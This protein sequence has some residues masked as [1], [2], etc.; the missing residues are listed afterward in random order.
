MGAADSLLSLPTPPGSRGAPH[1]TTAWR[2]VPAG[3][4][5]KPWDVTSPTLVSVSASLSVQHPPQH[6][7]EGPDPLHGAPQTDPRVRSVWCGRGGAAPGGS[8]AGRRSR[9]QPVV[10]TELVGES[11]LKTGWSQNSS[12]L[13]RSTT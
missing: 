7:P 9:R 6:G 3:A 11:L 2:K 12:T 1:A 10:P 4:L 5:G 8:E 13:A